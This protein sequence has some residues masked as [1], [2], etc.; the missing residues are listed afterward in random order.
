MSGGG[1]GVLIRYEAACRAVAEAKSVDEVKEFLAGAAALDAYA[2]QAKNKSLE[3]DAFEIRMRA[4]RQVGF[5]MRKQ[6]A[7]VGMATGTAGQGRPPLGGFQENPPKTQLPTLAE[8]GIDKN[9]AHRA[10]LAARA[11]VRCSLDRN[12]IVDPPWGYP[13]PTSLSGV[14][15]SPERPSLPA[16]VGCGGF[17]RGWGVGN[18]RFG[19]DFCKFSGNLLRFCRMSERADEDG[20]RGLSRALDYRARSTRSGSP[21]QT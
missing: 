17:V 7:M 21:C 9:P 16:R 20:A 18:R 3:A 19:A 12:P 8:A 5:L 13:T 15:A 14:G 4:E 1:E 11:A 6:K 10:R 2:R